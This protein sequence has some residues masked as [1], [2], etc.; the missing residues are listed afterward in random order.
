MAA[1]LTG[2]VG[3][4]LSG[5]GRSQKSYR[6]YLDLWFDWCALNGLDPL[7]DVRRVHI[8]T[9]GVWHVRE[10]HVKPSW[11]NGAFTVICGFYRYAYEEG[12]IP[13]DPGVNVRRP[14]VRRWSE[15]SWLTE[16]ESRRFLVEAAADRRRFV[17]GCVCLLLLN[18]LRSGEVTRLNV[19]DFRTVDGMPVV[20]VRR[21]FDWMQDV[22]LSEYT[23]RVLRDLVGGRDSGALFRCNG[24][25]VDAKL[26]VATVAGI[27]ERIGCERRITPHSLRR[28]FATLAREHGVPDL[29]IMAS[30]GWATPMMIDYY[31]MAR[32][33]VTNKATNVV[34]DLLS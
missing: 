4:Y 8:E 22:G 1:T 10:R 27:G 19:P 9:F 2:L 7:C 12:C 6:R 13:V 30:A 34:S 11:V 26:L 3:G 29:E 32:L 20:H 17:L 5:V 16:R 31:D 18:G 14:R 28:T 33:S 21:K 25:R 23:S 15:G 24:K